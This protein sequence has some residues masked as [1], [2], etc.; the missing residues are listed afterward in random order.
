MPKYIKHIKAEGLLGRFT[1]DQT[2]KPGINVLYGKNGTGKTTLLHV[3]ANLLNGDYKRFAHIK[4]KEIRIEFDDESHILVRREK[5]EN[6]YMIT[7]FKDGERF[8]EDIS[9]RKTVEQDEKELYVLAHS[10][11]ESTPPRELKKWLSD[12]DDESMRPMLP[13]AYFPAFRTMIEAW[14][15]SE[16]NRR[17]E[18]K[19][20]QYL[21]TNFAR[22]LFGS[23]VPSLNYP[24][25][26]EIEYE[27]SS[28]IDAARGQVLRADAELF[29]ELLP[30]F[31]QV[32][33]KT[34]NNLTLSQQK[35]TEETLVEIDDLVEKLRKYPLK[36]APTITRL[37]DSI[38][39]FQNQNADEKLQIIAR[40]VLTIY[41]DALN[42]IV[43]FQE[44]TFNNIEVYLNSINSFLEGKRVEISLA[45]TKFM[46]KSL[47]A[48]YSRRPLIGIK[49]DSSSELIPGIHRALS[50]GER[51][52]IT[53]IYAATHMSEQEVVLIDEPEIS[54]HVDWQRYLLQK[55]SAQ[56][57]ERQIIV[58]THS[59][60]IGADYE[61]RVIIFNPKITDI[62][63]NDE[64]I[65]EDGMVL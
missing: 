47:W 20:I 54:L 44:K 48:R 46:Q 19:E 34:D 22:E 26:L 32:L 15:S 14:V 30:K 62:E 4:F 6:S 52:L 33:S 11:R 23:F 24:S 45:D 21:S 41:R 50:S 1:I 2:F 7:V 31:F 29:G 63:E 12:D 49:F 5:K 56:L 61:E 59:P 51:Q 35:S 28:E 3:L 37:R 65:E 36:I 38:S 43:L 13:V 10:Y 55:M 64:L 18:P 40:Q 58:C 42:N 16:Y 53:L 39:P 60:V 17:R 27:L 9:V 25:P 8:I 57:G